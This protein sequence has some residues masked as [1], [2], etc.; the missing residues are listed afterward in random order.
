MKNKIITTLIISLLVITQAIADEIK[1]PHITVTGKVKMMVEPDQMIWSV[2]VVN[3][4]LSLKEVAEN[5]SSIVGDVI[6]LLTEMD[7]DKDQIQTSRMQ[8]GEN[9]VYKGGTRVKEGF[10]AHTDISFKLLKLEKYNP[11]WMGLSKKEN[12]SVREVKYSISDP[13]SYQ[14]EARK[15]ALIS[16]KEKAVS[17]AGV[18]GAKLGEPLAIKEDP[19]FNEG[20]RESVSPNR[21][22]FKAKDGS[23][24]ISVSPGQLPVIIRVTVSFRLINSD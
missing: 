10:Y 23:G 2:N 14:N 12:V 11:L 19:S 16:A 22:S 4:G 8:F 5:H 17:M 21:V 1:I 18:L 15:D 9:W 3:R 24:D 13:E 7:I 20:Y 6:S